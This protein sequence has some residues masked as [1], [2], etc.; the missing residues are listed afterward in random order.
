MLGS[1]PSGS[2]IGNDFRNAYVP[3]TSLNGSGTDGR[4]C[5][6]LI[7][8]FLQSDITAYETLAGLPNVPCPSGLVGRDMA[9]AIGMR[10]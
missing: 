7:R 5:W 1:G 8:V 6:N 4:A 3:G 10:Q 9:E 2:Y